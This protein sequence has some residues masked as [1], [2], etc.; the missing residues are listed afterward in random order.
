[1]PDKFLSKKVYYNIQPPCLKIYC[2][3]FSLTK[4]E[5]NICLIIIFA[6]YDLNENIPWHDTPSP[7]KKST[8]E[9]ERWINTSRWQD[10]NGS[11]V[12]SWGISNDEQYSF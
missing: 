3:Y 9:L 10:D 5:L 6:S 11:N 7:K 2:E 12:F 8:K 1:M 4:F